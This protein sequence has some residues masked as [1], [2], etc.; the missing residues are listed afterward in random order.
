ML[1]GLPFPDQNREVFSNLSRCYTRF[2]RDKLEQ[3]YRAPA[4]SSKS[5]AFTWVLLEYH[6]VSRFR[7]V[8]SATLAPHVLPFPRALRRGFLFEILPGFHLPINVKLRSHHGPAKVG[9][10]IG[11]GS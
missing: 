3:G 6:A 11:P 7:R 2:Q 10:V 8:V 4:S 5:R 9:N 1:S